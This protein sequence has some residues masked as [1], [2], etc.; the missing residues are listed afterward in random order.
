MFWRSENEVI[1]EV[2]RLLRRVIK[3]K[4]AWTNKD[5]KIV[6]I[7]EY[8]PK[9]YEKFFEENEEY[10]ILTIAGNGYTRTNQSFNT[11][12]GAFQSSIVD[13][14]TRGLGLALVDS[15]H[16]LS[17]AIP[18]TIDDDDTLHGLEFYALSSEQELNL[19]TLDI[20]LRQ[21]SY[22]GS[23]V[24]SASVPYIASTDYTRYF[25]EFYPLTVLTESAYWLTFSAQAGNSFLIGIDDT[26]DNV[27]NYISGSVIQASGSLQGRLFTP[28]IMRL[29][30]SIEGTITIK[31]SDKN[32][33]QKPREILSIIANYINLLTQAQLTRESGTNNTTLAMGEDNPVDEWLRKDIRIKGVKQGSSQERRRG[34]NDIIHSYDLSI[35]YYTEWNE[36]YQKDLLSEINID[37]L[38]INTP[39]DQ[40]SQEQINLDF[41]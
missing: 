33:T 6:D 8:T 18:T 9:I 39:G 10:P 11:H 32:S 26:A 37:L 31:C 20:Q 28:P 27:F 13:M 38:D 7:S 24:S 19:E 35:D 36:D 2:I 25:T 30:G 23:I 1:I 14:G 3:Y 41:D 40:Y 5:F 22:S 15:A 17:F 16:G 21:G 29:G 4:S 12:L 34:E